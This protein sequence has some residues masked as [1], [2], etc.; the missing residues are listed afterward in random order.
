[1]S[2]IYKPRPHTCH[3]VLYFYAA[4]SLNRICNSVTAIVLMAGASDSNAVV[5]SNTKFVS[6]KAHTGGGIAVN[7]LHNSYK[8]IGQGNNLLIENCK[9]TNNT[10]FQGA[11]A[12]FSKNIKFDQTV[13]N[14]TVSCVL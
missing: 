14:T 4:S 11:S 5:I 12:Y 6:N 1:M 3:Y 2:T 7:V 13:L 9:F 10:G 8:Y